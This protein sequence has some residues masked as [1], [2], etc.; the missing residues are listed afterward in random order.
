[1]SRQSSLWLTR[2]YVGSYPN[3]SARFFA[4]YTTNDL[5]GLSTDVRRSEKLSWEETYKEMSE[6]LEDWSD[7]ENLEDSWEH[8][9]GWEDIDGM[10]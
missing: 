7:W 1:M 2:K 9:E 3:S 4:F 10:L 6:S 5:L 8:L